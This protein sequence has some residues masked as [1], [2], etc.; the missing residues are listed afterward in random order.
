MVLD[1]PEG[2]D[3][4]ISRG[5]PRLEP[6]LWCPFVLLPM[7]NKGAKVWTVSLQHRDMDRV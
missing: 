7:E 1:E 5:R 2:L 4:M 6:T 3:L